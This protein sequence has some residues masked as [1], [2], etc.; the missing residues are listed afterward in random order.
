MGLLTGASLAVGLGVIAP[1]AASAIDGKSEGPI[2]LSSTAAGFSATSNE[3]DDLEQVE[4]SSSPAEKIT[5][6]NLDQGATLFNQK[7][8]NAGYLIEQNAYAGPGEEPAYDPNED[9]DPSL[10]EGEEGDGDLIVEERIPATEMEPLAEEDFAPSKAIAVTDN[11]ISL[12]WIAPESSDGTIVTLDGMPVEHLDNEVSFTGLEPST[13]YEVSL[14]HL[15]GDDTV[16][17]D[18]HLLETVGEGISDP[19]SR[20][21]DK[22]KVQ[23]AAVQQGALSIRYLTFIND[24]KVRVGVLPSLGCSASSSDYF[25][26][27]DRVYTYPRPVSDVT[28]SASHR[29]AIDVKAELS[30]PPE[31]QELY[32]GKSIGATH[33]YNE[34]Q[35]L[36]ETRRASADGIVVQNPQISPN[37]YARFGVSHEVANPFCFAGA[38]R[39]VLTEVQIYKSGTISVS[40]SRVPVPA[41]ELYGSFVNSNGTGQWRQLYQGQQGNFNCLTGACPN[42]SISGNA[43]AT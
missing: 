21:A 3:G 4:I 42:E 15:D 36:I 5:A 7:P 22:D 33:L 41:H 8:S 14:Q 11:S 40:G 19:I 32:V 29:S 12:N 6:L 13:Q 24:A 20:Q 30:A 26:G 37:S 17:T 16:R 43:S 25:G 2:Q 31:Y 10:L 34:N 27:D 38:I 39:W 1:T 9:I 35:N 28:N 18:T 23:A